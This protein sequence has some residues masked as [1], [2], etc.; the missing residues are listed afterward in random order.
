MLL[1]KIIFKF[2]RSDVI[3]IAI[4]K[5]EIVAMENRLHGC[6]FGIVIGGIDVIKPVADLGGGI[7]GMH[8]PPTA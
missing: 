1:Q 3:V 7:G 8:P 5:G 2:W 6:V 4:I